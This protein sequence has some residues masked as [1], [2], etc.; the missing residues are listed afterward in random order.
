VYPIDDDY[1]EY[2]DE[3]LIVDISEIAPY[4]K[5]KKNIYR[6]LAEEGK[7]TSAVTMSI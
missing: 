1:D 7:F 2:D 3:P 5:S 4:M 6:I